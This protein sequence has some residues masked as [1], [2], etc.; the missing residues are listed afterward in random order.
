MMGLDKQSGSKLPPPKRGRAGVGVGAPPASSRFNRKSEMT[1]RARD[2]RRSMSPIEQRLW[3]GLR[4]AQLGATFRRQHPA[5]GYVLDF[6]CSKAKLAVELDGDEH[7]S[8]TGRDAMRTRFLN[9]RGIH[10][11]RFSNR[12]VCSNLD[13]V[14]EMIALELERLGA[15]TPTRR[16]LRVDLPLSRGGKE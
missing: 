9:G 1:H 14:R 11:V 12:D 15:L 16:A 2:L 8:R 7:A 6:Y 10:V 13:G 4:G 3:R 5:G